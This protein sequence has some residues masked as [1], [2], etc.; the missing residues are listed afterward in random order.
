MTDTEWLLFGGRTRSCCFTAVIV[1]LLVRFSL[2]HQTCNKKNLCWRHLRFPA[3]LRPSARKNHH[4]LHIV[5][6]T[7]STCHRRH[8]KILTHLT[9]LFAFCV[10]GINSELAAHMFNTVNWRIRKE[11][12]YTERL[13]PFGTI[14]LVDDQRFLTSQKRKSI[15]HSIS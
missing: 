13:Q 14:R 5:H 15:L 9:C 3:E 2:M 8:L 1:V 6:T 7:L 10:A 12:K 4:E 11:R